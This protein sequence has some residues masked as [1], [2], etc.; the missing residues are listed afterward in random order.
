[1]PLI[2]LF[3]LPDGMC[4][5][6][7]KSGLYAITGLLLLMGGAGGETSYSFLE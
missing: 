2:T 7:D 6:Q 3:S 1:M 4:Y 5:G